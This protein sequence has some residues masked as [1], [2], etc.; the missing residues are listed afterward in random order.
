MRPLRQRSEKIIHTLFKNN[1]WGKPRLSRLKSGFSHILSE[2][3]FGFQNP[4]APGL[5]GI[6]NL[7]ST[8]EL[9]IKAPFGWRFGGDFCDF[10]KKAHKK[11]KEKP[12]SPFSLCQNVVE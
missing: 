6:G 7:I 2:N 11:H 1:P 3:I 4:R 12:R 9:G 5:L 8:A 10:L